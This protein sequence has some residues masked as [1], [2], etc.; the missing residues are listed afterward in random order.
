MFLTFRNTKI[1]IGVRITKKIILIGIGIIIFIIIVS[2]KTNKTTDKSDKAL[3]PSPPA[4]VQ[5]TA[6][7]TDTP[8]IVIKEPTVT[9]PPYMS[10]EE[11]G[12]GVLSVSKRTI[13]AGSLTSLAITLKTQNRYDEALEKEKEAE[14]LFLEAKSIND[15]LKPPPQYQKSY[16]YYVK[17]LELDIESIKLQIRATEHFKSGEIE[18]SNLEQKQAS[19]LLKEAMSYT[20]LSTNTMQ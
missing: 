4:T 20:R 1:L 17:A 2:S 14:K 3:L 8:T 19:D 10:K 9:T 7:K 18:L 5:S 11:Y 15:S 16:D 6:T 12:K 13:E